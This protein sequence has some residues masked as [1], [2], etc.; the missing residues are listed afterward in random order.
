MPKFNLLLVISSVP[1]FGVLYPKLNFLQI[2]L[3]ILLIYITTIICS[4][5]LPLLIIFVIILSCLYFCIVI[6]VFRQGQAKKNPKAK[7][8]MNKFSR[9]W[10]NQAG[11]S[12]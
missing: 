4:P 3:G 8:S 5:L 7:S 2:F 10:Y 1:Y 9:S 6:H 11:N 12:A